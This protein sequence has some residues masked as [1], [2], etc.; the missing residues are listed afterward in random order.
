[1][2]QSERLENAIVGCLSGAEGRI[3]ESVGT[4]ITTVASL[5][6]QLAYV[7]ISLQYLPRAIAEWV[8][9]SSSGQM[10][11]SIDKM[12]NHIDGFAASIQTQQS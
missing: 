7:I 6:D 3:N 8:Y 2:I 1:M 10:S 9:R 11:I 5:Q 12:N 4:V